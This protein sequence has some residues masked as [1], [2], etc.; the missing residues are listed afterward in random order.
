[1]QEFAYPPD[2]PYLQ[3]KEVR[4]R[5]T[6]DL[7][8]YESLDYEI[9]D[10]DVALA[11]FVTLGPKGHRLH[12]AI[13]W[14]FC[15][16][17]GVSMAVVA[18]SVNLAA[19][20]IAA[21]KFHA[22]Q[23]YLNDDRKGAAF[24]GY[25]GIN[26]ACAL[27][28]VLVVTLVAPSAAGSGIPDVK[29]YL[30]GINVLGVLWPRTLLAKAVGSIGAVAAGLPVGKE[31]PFVHIGSCIAS[32]LGHGGF[33]DWRVRWVPIQTFRSDREQRDLVTTG[34][35]AG[36]A[37]AFRAPVGGVLFALEE[38]TSWWRAQ[39]TWRTFFTNA[40]V[41][42]TVNA[43]VSI[44]GTHC[45]L[46]GGKFILFGITE[47]SSGF[48]TSDLLPVCILGV[49]GGLLGSLFTYLNVRVTLWRQE[50]LYVWAK[51]NLKTCKILEVVA[52]A[53]LSSAVTFYLPYV[54]G[55]THCPP[56]ATDCPQND[57][58]GNFITHGCDAGK[59]EYS[60]LGSLLFTPQDNAIKNLFSTDTIG[61]FS[62]MELLI[63]FCSYFPLAVLVYGISV[64]S[65]LFIPGIL[66]GASYGR[67]MGMLV[68]RYT[69][70]TN[71]NV[72]LDESTYAL[73]GAASFLG[74]SMR[75]TVS[76]CVILVELTDQLSLIPLL[77]LALIISKS[78]GDLLGIPGIYDAHIKLKHVPYLHSQ[79]ERKYRSTKISDVAAAPVVSF[80]SFESVSNIVNTLHGTTHNGF[81]V[82]QDA[83]MRRNGSFNGT[84][85]ASISSIG[86]KRLLGVVLRSDLLVVLQSRINFQS[87]PVYDD[88]VRRRSYR[89]KDRHFYKRGA[90][91]QSPSVDD[92]RLSSQDMNK[93]VDLTPFVNR[94]CYVVHE[95]SNLEKVYAEFRK[96]G[97][98]HLCVVPKPKEVLGVITRKDIMRGPELEKVDELDE[99]VMSWQG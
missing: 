75:M 6:Q 5:F 46:G 27:V 77:M 2:N 52:F 10:S 71:P 12:V 37:A 36:V 76:L 83:Q 62:I 53:I 48:L 96:L 78:V 29:A 4:K 79:A 97:L 34:A 11:E 9:K 21:A 26:V 91:V 43:F 69:G 38:V 72:D 44:C 42:V 7:A 3:R 33:G 65:G 95:D 93:W 80:D 28:A 51:D 90:T 63:F 68:M 23:T 30:N 18:F 85:P 74:G 66:C 73:I 32:I 13:K 86:E 41:L 16:L 58:I 84:E 99:E 67:I 15:F 87:A 14:V 60:P 45:G 39:L 49:I 82:F 81:P 24:V 22:I 40:V 57:V 94:S 1:V 89:Y 70:S 25:A 50:V 8:Q 17:I 19:V 20:N 56:D 88:M 31:G 55:C 59:H 64:P 61:E 98:R 54:G 47:P 35:A 92:I